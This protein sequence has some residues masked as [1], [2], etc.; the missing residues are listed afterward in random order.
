MTAARKPSSEV[1]IVAVEIRSTAVVRVASPM[2]ELMGAH[3]TAHAKLKS[4]LPDLDAGEV[5]LRA[6]LWYPPKDGVLTMEP[7]RIVQRSFKPVGEVVP[8]ELPGGRAAQLH[9]RGPWHA[10]P[11]A[12][13]RLFAWTAEQKL[14]LAGTNWEIYAEEA[15]DPN[16]QEAR[17]YALLA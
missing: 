10:L 11:G 7:G 17:L 15:K 5:C 1:S 14:A 4:A 13:A 2:S 6:T 8:S 3:T 9:F 16:G 12:W